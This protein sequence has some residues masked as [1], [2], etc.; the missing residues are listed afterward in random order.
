MEK[1]VGGRSWREVSIMFRA[2]CG[3]LGLSETLS[4]RCGAASICQCCE[5]GE[6]EDV[7]HFIAYC[8]AFKVLRREWLQEVERE[9]VAVAPESISEIVLG[10][11]VPGCSFDV[12]SSCLSFL[13]SLWNS[14]STKL[15]GS[16]AGVH[17]KSFAKI[18]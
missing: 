6:I 9:G 3:S 17:G 4:R 14:R 11:E 2:R 16:A 5:S 8:P 13:L 12:A 18:H 7:E 10:M 15:Y 1:Y